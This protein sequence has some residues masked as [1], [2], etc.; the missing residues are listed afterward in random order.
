MTRGD[1]TIVNM[2]LLFLAYS[3][4]KCVVHNFKDR[5]E[6]RFTWY[7]GKSLIKSLSSP[8]FYWLSVLWQYFYL[9]GFFIYKYII[10][11]PLPYHLKI[12]E[13]IVSFS[14]FSSIL[15]FSSKISS[16]KK[17]FSFLL[18]LLSQL[19]RIQNY[20][21]QVYFKLVIA[22]LQLVYVPDSSL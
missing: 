7:H 19:I 11:L 5:E 15:L 6:K 22:S 20:R 4:K 9:L 1:K 21:I 16:K 18:F 14:L 12:W 13:G 8:S 10:F 17:I 2:T 3:K